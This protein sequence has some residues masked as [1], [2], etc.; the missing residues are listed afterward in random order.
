MN[1]TLPEEMYTLPSNTLDIIGIIEKTP[2]RPLKIFI[3]ILAILL[4]MVIIFVI[5]TNTVYTLTRNQNI[6]NILN[7]IFI[8][9]YIVCA[10]IGVVYVLNYDAIEPLKEKYP[11]E[12]TPL[13]KEYPMMFIAIYP[14]KYV[15]TTNYE[16]IKLSQ[17]EDG[18][19]IMNIDMKRL[20]D[21]NPNIFKQIDLLKNGYNKEK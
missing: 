8:Y 9:G 10:V 16:V 13:K 4:I 15:L 12:L 21:E 19:V 6:T 7:E 3:Q 1:Y 11:K 2:H 17:V 5:I 14:Q 18:D 20:R